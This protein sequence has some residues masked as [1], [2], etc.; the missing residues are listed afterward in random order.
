MTSA[1]VC[2]FCQRCRIPST[3]L[4]LKQITDAFFL[5][6]AGSDTIG[7]HDLY[8]GLVRLAMAK[9]GQMRPPAALATLMAFHVQPYA[10]RALDDDDIRARIATRDVQALYERYA[11]ALRDAFGRYAINGA[12]QRA[13]TFGAVQTMLKDTGLVVDDGAL[14]ATF[15]DAAGEPTTTTTRD[16]T[17]SLVY[18]EYLEALARVADQRYR[19]KVPLDVKLERLFG[20]VLFVEAATSTGARSASGVQ[21]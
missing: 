5:H 19:E 6:R 16:P 7:R 17:T 8:A 18:A 13:I 10:L 3:T 12:G 4:T 21:E 2:A 14:A 20:E 11:G 1:A 9:Y 15:E